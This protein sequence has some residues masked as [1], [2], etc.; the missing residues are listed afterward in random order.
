MRYSIWIWLFSAFGLYAQNTDLRISIKGEY[1]DLT[2]TLVK[3]QQDN[4]DSTGLYKAMN[5]VKL[6]LFERGYYLSEG[7][8]VK[9]DSLAL[10]EVIPGPSL[11]WANVQL[12]VPDSFPL[13]LPQGLSL[14]GKGLSEK[15][16][17]DYAHTYLNFLEN[18]GY[19]FAQLHFVDYSL[20]NDSIRGT[21]EVIPGPLITLDSLVIKGYERFSRNVLRYDLRFE[22]G[23]VYDEAYIQKLKEYINQIEYLRF[24]RAPAVA[25]S[26]DKTILFLYVEEVKSNQVDG[27]I[28]LNTK[29]DGEVTFNGDF[30]LRLLN[31]LKRGEEIKVR[32]RRPDESISEL[33]LGLTLPYI[34]NT[35]FWL[36]GNLNIFRQDSSF[37]NTEAEGLLKYLIESGSFLSG[38]LDYRASNV[39][40]DGADNNTGG[41]L[42]SF[43]TTAY[44]LGYERSAVNRIIVP[45][46][47]NILRIY[48]ST[49]IRKTSEN[50]QR[51]YGWFI[52][53]EQYFRIFKNHILKLGVNSRALIGDDLFDNEVFRIGGLK[54]LRGFNERSI[55][56]SSYGIGTL[57][58]RYMLGEYDYLTLFSDMAYVENNTLSNYSV[59]YFLGVGAGLN[60]RTNGGIFSLFYALGKDNL[61]PFDFRTSKIHFGYINRF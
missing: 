7:N 36:E 4:L 9:Q 39:L 47:G 37:V 29:E 14:E 44:K 30:Q 13:I 15:N 18:R 38:G 22:K 26:K 50:S 48:G 41:N 43:N 16:L 33:D 45:T 35:A 12:S 28:G 2:N 52:T 56:A 40:M 10:L 55:Y 5:T 27:I 19:P 61:N 23:M 3:H 32:W 24:A 11:L 34:A 57:E 59:N 60:F 49:G 20:Q 58:Y 42:N 31:V 21:L 17:R 8:L 25:F 46:S 53:D 6:D 54:S 51:Q 1:P